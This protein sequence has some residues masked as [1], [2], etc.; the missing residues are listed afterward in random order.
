[1]FVTGVPMTRPLLLLLPLALLS[2]ALSGCPTEVPPPPLLIT[3]VSFTNTVVLP[4][5]TIT[6]EVTVEGA[7]GDPAFEWLAEAGELSAP[8]AAST[9]WTAPDVEQLVAVSVTVTDGDRTAEHNIDL[10]VG[11]GLDHD[12]DGFSLREGDCDDTNASIYPGAADISDGL[13]ND[14]DG[15]VDE[16]S[17]DADDDGDG[18]ADVDG[19]CDDDNANVFPGSPEGSTADGLDND[20]DGTTDEGTEAFDD[21][22]DGFSEDDGDCNDNS[23]AVAPNA[24]ETLDNIDNDCDG[25]TDE[26]TAAYDDDGDGW[27]ELAGDCNDAPD[28]DGPEQYP[29]YPE[30]ADGLDNDCDGLA[31]ED[32]LVDNDGD[33]WSA[34]AGDCDDANAYTYPGAPEFLDTLD[35]DCNGI[36]DDGMD[37]VDDDG[38]G[39]AEDGDGCDDGLGDCDDTADSIFP[40][41]D[42]VDDVPLDLDND[43]DGFFFVNAPFALAS[44]SSSGNC[45]NGADDDGDGWIDAFDPD[46]TISTAEG[47]FSVTACNDGLDT[48]GDG[49]VDSADPQCGNG[50]DNDEED[51]SAD[52]CQNGADDDGDGWIDSD[53]PGC[54]TLPFDETA[55]AI[56]ACSDGA[57]NDGDGNID[58]DDAECS[59]G[60]DGSESDDGP[61]DCSDGLDSDADGWIDAEDPD[62]TGAP[63][64]EDGL[65]VSGCNDGIDNDGDGATDGQDAGCTDANDNDELTSVGGSIVLDGTASWDPD[66]DALIH[67]WYFDFQPINSSLDTA[68]ILD[69]DNPIASFAPDVAGTWVVGLIVSDGQFNSDPALL[70]I[71][72]AE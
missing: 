1:M 29:G 31:D 26:G 53:D 20:C 45:G 34:L 67:Y 19:D 38:D 8:A 71:Q 23:S 64:D 47:G 30:V 14:C 24:P 25:T 28:A 62:C 17:P 37:S 18:F 72:V 54:A 42:E 65:G 7:Q 68:D 46:C 39:C 5:E 60:F 32:F 33:G 41:A 16:G 49:A 61:D 12:G 55:V 21:D 10:V 2:L 70:I 3:Q 69:G 43:C 48:D 59:D 35:N 22:G 57:D 27:T 4:G 51:A 58:A 52:D 44:L 50:F 63:F 13:D 36:A 66:G 15:E 9:D 6:M 40:G 56:T 11:Y